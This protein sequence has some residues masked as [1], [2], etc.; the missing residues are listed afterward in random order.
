MGIEKSKVVNIDQLFKKFV[1]K[2]EGGNMNILA[3]IV[4]I[5]QN[6]G[7]FTKDLHK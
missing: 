3:Y 2:G 1:L 5:A 7:M 4:I 6:T